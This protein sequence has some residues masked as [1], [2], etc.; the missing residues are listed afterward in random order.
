VQKSPAFPVRIAPLITFVQ[1]IPG[2]STQV[3]EQWWDHGVNRIV[4]I[5]LDRLSLAICRVNGL[6]RMSNLNPNHRRARPSHHRVITDEQPWEPISPAPPSPSP[7]PYSSP[8]GKGMATSYVGQVSPHTKHHDSVRLSSHKGITAPSLGLD[9]RFEQ[10]YLKS[11]APHVRLTT[12]T[13]DENEK[14]GDLVRLQGQRL[15]IGWGKVIW[16]TTRDQVFT[17]MFQGMIW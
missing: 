9:L 2:G 14:R 3:T 17:P 16:I 5:T 1:L 6:L 8:A 15:D 11:I 13:S 10:T 12:P 7:S 4:V